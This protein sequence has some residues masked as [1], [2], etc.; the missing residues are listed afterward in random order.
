VVLML[1]TREVAARFGVT[2][3]TVRYWVLRGRL[4]PA[5]TERVAVFWFDEQDV[6]RF[7]KT[8]RVVTDGGTRQSDG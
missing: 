6:D 5:R 2:P 3:S 1:S 7:A 4:T 8:Y